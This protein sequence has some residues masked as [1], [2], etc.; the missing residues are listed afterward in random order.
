MDENSIDWNDAR[1]RFLRS[2]SATFPRRGRD[3][4]QDLAS[5][6]IVRL[7]RV[8]RRERIDKIHGLIEKIAH[9]VAADQIRQWKRRT[10]RDA[11]MDQREPVFD[12][13]SIDHED[14]DPLV[15]RRWLLLAWFQRHDPRVHEV[16][17]RRMKGETL[18]DIAELDRCSYDAL[19]Q[20]WHRAVVA[21]LEAIAPEDPIWEWV[22]EHD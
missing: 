7:L 18:R 5:E 17:L 11:S 8:A 13:G 3:L 19:R 12:G 14:Q 22:R 1:Q 6:G 16:A 15:R 9:D 2:F 20:Q 4:H 21:F 10:A